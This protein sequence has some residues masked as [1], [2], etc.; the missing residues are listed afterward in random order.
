MSQIPPADK[1]PAQVDPAAVPAADPGVEQNLHNFWTQNRNF[2]FVLCVIVLVGIIAR[3]GW[4]YFSS[5]REKSIEQDYAQVADKPDR[6]AAFAEANAGHSLAGIAYLQ[7]ADRKF[8]AAD[9]KEASSM[10]T[11]AAGSLKNEALLGR[12]KVGAAVSLINS[13]DA[14]GGESA[15]KAVSSDGSLAKSSRAEAAYHLASLASDAGRTDDVRKYVEDANKN[16]QTGAWAQRA[17]MLLA[18]LPGAKDAAITPN[19]APKPAG[20]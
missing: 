19:L 5:A 8:E 17:T 10:Y 16:D 9:Y 7:I 15:L 18:D 6:L 11:K 1:A 12:A 13:G 2:I 3:E 14:A 20:K 4:G